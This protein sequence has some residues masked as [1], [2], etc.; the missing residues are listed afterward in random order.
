MSDVEI[1]RRQA[2]E[3]RTEELL[4]ALDDIAAGD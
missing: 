2:A 1:S 4:R 3:N